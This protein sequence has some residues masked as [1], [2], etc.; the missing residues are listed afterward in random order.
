MRLANAIVQLDAKGRPVAPASLLH[1]RAAY[2]AI[3]AAA[4]V[5][6]AVLAPYH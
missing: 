6:L 4:I 5:V 1:Q 3:A 2:R